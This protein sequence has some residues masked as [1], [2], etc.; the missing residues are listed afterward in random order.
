MKPSK[1]RSLTLHLALTLALGL[2]ALLC[3]CGDDGPAD[4]PDDGG[5]IGRGGGTIAV[6]DT[7][8]LLAGVSFHVPA[9]AW[10]DC[11]SVVMLY[12]ST[13]STPNFPD[14]LEGYDGWLTGGIEL[15][16]GRADGGEWT[17][18]PDS[19]DFELT[20]P[21][22]HLTAAPGEKI[23]AFRYDEAAGLYRLVLPVRQDATSITVRG[24]H[25]RQLWTWGKIDIESIDFETYLTPVMEELHGVGGWLEIRAELERLQAEAVAEQNAITCAT[26]QIV[27][28]GFVGARE[29]AADNVRAIQSGL[30]RCGTC[31]ALTS[32]FYEDL[33]EYIKLQVGSYLVDLF[34][35][36]SRSLLLK[37][38]SVIMC[39]YLEYCADQLPCDYECFADA[40]GLDFYLNLAFY[41]ASELA[42]E[43]IDWAMIS[44]YVD[45]TGDQAVVLSDRGPSPAGWN[46]YSSSSSLCPSAPPTLSRRAR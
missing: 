34:F 27:R 46:V 4:V 40:V 28:A 12:H 5:C 1:A 14:G 32:E 2:S 42:V 6:T 22:R 39:S 10:N 38:Y 26:L 8:D 30:T 7:T 13:F 41:Y 36:E 33:G 15:E 16:I 29:A 37:L 25:T 11:W 9:G 23:V 19:L 18:A 44:G 43:L 3:S 21:L 20:L 35:G 31:D 24:H 17:S 45:C